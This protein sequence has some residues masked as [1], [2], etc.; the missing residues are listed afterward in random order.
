MIVTAWSSLLLGGAVVCL[1]MALITRR[2]A[3]ASMA[4]A[5]ASVVFGVMGALVGFRG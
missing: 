5:L 4:W 1:L 3:G 2:D